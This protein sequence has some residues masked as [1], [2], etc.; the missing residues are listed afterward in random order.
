MAIVRDMVWWRNRAMAHETKTASSRTYTALVDSAV[1]HNRLRDAAPDLLA[2][3]GDVLPSKIQGDRY[4]VLR[5]DKSGFWSVK[6]PRE[7][8]DIFDKWA[9]RHAAAIAKAEGRTP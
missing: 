1:A 8:D 2:V 5:A 9:A 3:L 6:C 4:I 7:M